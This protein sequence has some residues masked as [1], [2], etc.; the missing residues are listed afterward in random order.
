M[1]AFIELLGNVGNEVVK[2]TFK[3]GTKY[4]I[5]QLLCRNTVDD[6]TIWFNCLVQEG[7]PAY[8]FVEACNLKKGDLVL[9][10]GKF[11]QKFTWEEK[12]V[13][14]RET[15]QKEVMK[16]Q[17]CRN[18]VYVATATIVERAMDKQINPEIVITKDTK[19]ISNNGNKASWNYNDN[20]FGE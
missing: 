20:P 4:I 5:F 10:R 9:T 15:M 8:T 17:N 6:D 18:R 3:N 12:V 16:V 14:N 1:E 2:G 11:Q 13:V 7:I 19:T